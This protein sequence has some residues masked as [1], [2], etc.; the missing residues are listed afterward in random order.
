MTARSNKR[1]R[2]VG[3]GYM[4]LQ[5][6]F[7]KLRLPFDSDESQNC[8]SKS[9]KKIYYSALK[10]SCD[11]AKELGPHPSFNETKAA[12]GILQYD[13]W[14]VTVTD[15]DRWESLAGKSRPMAC[16]TL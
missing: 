10:T 9:Q 2:P 14:D 15:E 13:F 12:K 4:G 5:D 7:F 8:L 11:L 3:L 1:W 16:A 6:V